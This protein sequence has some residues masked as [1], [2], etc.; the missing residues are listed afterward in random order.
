MI[1]SLYKQIQYTTA[2]YNQSQRIF[3]H[4]VYPYI[5][6]QQTSVLVHIL[7]SLLL[8]LKLYSKHSTLIKND[9]NSTTYYSILTQMNLIK[10]E[11]YASIPSAQ[12]SGQQIIFLQR[13]DGEFK[14][15]IKL[16][17]QRCRLYFLELG[18]VIIKLLVIQQEKVLKLICIRVGAQ[19]YN[20][21]ILFLLKVRNPYIFICNVIIN[22]VYVQF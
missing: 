19:R 12:F 17:K 6:N 22:K 8:Y 10:P 7:N 15:Q 11:K 5:I 1:F 18:R 3:R 9:Q 16:H 13:R 20:K 4:D 2:Y 21:V 14:Y